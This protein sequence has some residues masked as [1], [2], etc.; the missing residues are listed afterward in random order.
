MTLSLTFWIGNV[1]GL[2]FTNMLQNWKDM[3]KK[4]IC[5]TFFNAMN[6]KL[7]AIFIQIANYNLQMDIKEQAHT[8]IL[9]RIDLSSKIGHISL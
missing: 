7:Y 6:S 4:D 1:N 9:I 2:L 3:S 8:N 5:P